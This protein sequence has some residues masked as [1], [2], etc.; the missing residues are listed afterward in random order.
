MNDYQFGA[1]NIYCV[2]KIC[3]FMIVVP[4]SFFIL[5][6][7]CS[8]NNPTEPEKP[9]SRTEYFVG[10]GGSNEYPGTREKP[11]RTIHHAV[12]QLKAGTTLTIL[13]GYYTINEMI[14]ITAR[15]S[16]KQNIVI[17]GEPGEKVVFDAQPANI[18]SSSQ[19]P[20]NQGVFQIE[21]AAY[22]QIRNIYVTNSHMSGFNIANS[23]YI[24]IINCTSRNSL[25]PG[26]AAW[27][28]CSHIKILGNTVINANDEN[29]SWTPFTG[30][31]APHEAISIGGPHYFEVAYNLVYDCR[32]EGIDCKETC[33][34]GIVHHNYVHHCDRQGLYIDGWFDVLEDV[35]MYANV[36]HDCEAGI[37]ISSENGPNS[38]NLKIHHNLVYNNRATGI[39]FSR[40]G[41][42]NTREN[43]HVYNNTFYQNGYGRSAN[44]DPNYWLT[45]GCYL[46]STQLKD[47]LIRNNIFAQ[48]KPFEIGHSGDYQEGDFEQKNIIIEYNLIYDVN[49]VDNPFYMSL[50][51]KD[52]VYSV[53]GENGITAE[54]GFVNASGLDFRLLSASP[55]VD[56][57]SPDAESNDPDGSR[58]DLGAFALGATEEYNWWRTNFP[59]AIE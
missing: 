35:E 24:D 31:E 36:V 33:V 46:F 59:P 3:R 42:D 9:L 7:A 58:N 19:Y 49:T 57:G 47:V 53:A 32:K 28:E 12:Q 1:K 56:A 13:K 34:H 5:F 27:Q 10:P 4:V 20:Y 29:M 40:W 2:V 55:A 51:A 16:S 45:G 22:I 54:P 30:N 41:D 26:I 6:C 23:D 8:K 15:G 48:N 50:W 43:V 21:N 18:G 17:R 38:K 25:C 14:K 44:G 11:W 39:F 37:A 52:W